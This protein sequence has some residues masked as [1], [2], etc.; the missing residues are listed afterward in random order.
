MFLRDSH[1]IYV[2]LAAFTHDLNVTHLG[3]AVYAQVVD[4]EVAV[5]HYL[6]AVHLSAHLHGGTFNGFA[7]S[8][9]AGAMVS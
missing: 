4:G 1:G 2:A 5:F 7:Q 3:G 9:N 8:A 6:S